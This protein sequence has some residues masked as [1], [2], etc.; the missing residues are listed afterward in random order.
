MSDEVNR[1][2][3]G[4]WIRKRLL[5]GQVPTAEETVTEAMSM[6]TPEDMRRLREAGIWIE[7]RLTLIQ[8]GKADE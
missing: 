5:A 3:L 8:G 2:N 7:P 1:R 6:L 4:D